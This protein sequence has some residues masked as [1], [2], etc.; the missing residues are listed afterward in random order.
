MI[1]EKIR[2]T[3][4]NKY[5]FYGIGIS[6]VAYLVGL[7]IAFRDSRT[8]VLSLLGLAALATIVKRP[9]WGLYLI[10]ALTPLNQLQQL[11]LPIFSSIIRIIGLV[12]I[13][14]FLARYFI[15]KEYRQIKT[16]LL[17]PIFIFVFAYIVGLFRAD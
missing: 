2:L 13:I 14:S 1:R 10:A 8:V 6:I 17:L 7:Q 16:D 5:L 11:E 4:I 3:F 9:I 12:T 15:T